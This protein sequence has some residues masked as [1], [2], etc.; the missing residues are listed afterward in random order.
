VNPALLLTA[1]QA[2]TKGLLPGSDPLS[3]VIGLLR[4]ALHLLAPEA[5]PR[6]IAPLPSAGAKQRIALCLGH[7]RA[8]DEGAEAVDGT[9]ER[10][11]NAA[12]IAKLIARLKAAGV[13]C[14]SVY[15]YKGSGYGAA[16]QWLANFLLEQK[17]TA[18][19]EF[20]FNSANGKAKGHETLY[21]ANSTR[22][23]T[24]ARDIDLA[25]DEEFRDE[26]DRNLKAI[27]S[28]ERG[29]TFLCLT[30]CPAAIVEPFFGDNAQQWDVFNSPEGTERLVEAYCN[31]ITN[32][33]S[34]QS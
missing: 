10:A 34:S 12:I 3:A 7:A 30:H 26:L 15:S 18:A 8:G 31:A 16:M 19:L 28:A 21:W 27:T 24:L 25:L 17:A 11:Y 23:V 4:D 5:D 2:L 32:W 33:I 20:H 22:G 29:A 9:T 1:Y 13:D 6:P 14:F